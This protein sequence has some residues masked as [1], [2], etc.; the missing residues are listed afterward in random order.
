MAGQNKFNI[1]NKGAGQS[2]SGL[3]YALLNAGGIY[4]R[5]QWDLASNL[6]MVAPDAI[7]RMVV[8]VAEESPREIQL[9]KTSPLPSGITQQIKRPPCDLNFHQND[10]GHWLGEPH[11]PGKN[12]GC[13]IS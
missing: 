13:T 3:V 4:R 11:L 12:T 6:F 9:A 10:F 2:C 8:L 1:F 7:A 5:A